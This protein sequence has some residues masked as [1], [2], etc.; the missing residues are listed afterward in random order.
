[1]Q[2]EAEYQV[3]RLNHHP[4]L[5]VWVGNNELELGLSLFEELFPPNISP[6]VVSQYETLFLGTL[7][8]AVF[9]NTRSISYSPSS[10]TNGYLSLNFS[11]PTPMVERCFNVT[12]G[13][14]DGNTDYYNYDP[15]QA[16]NNSAYPIG[17]FATEFGFHS[18]P[19]VQTWQQVAHLKNYISTLLLSSLTNI[20]TPPHLLSSQL[21]ILIRRKNHSVGWAR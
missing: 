20:T 10:I 7:L 16:F 15:G 6:L 3:R 19:S 14:I 21:V 9:L 11:S 1:V 18:M 12:P 5:A 13:T 4:S 17:R 8:L 2:A